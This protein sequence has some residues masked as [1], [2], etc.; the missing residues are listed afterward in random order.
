MP[1][2]TKRSDL[3]TWF[4]KQLRNAEPKGNVATGLVQVFDDMIDH[5]LDEN[6]SLDIVHYEW[7]YYFLDVFALIN[8][9]PGQ[10]R[11]STLVPEFLAVVYGEANA[12]GVVSG[13]RLIKVMMELLE[14]SDVDLKTVRTGGRKRLV[15]TDRFERQ[16]GVSVRIQLGGK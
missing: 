11:C 2:V 12:T 6:G 14:L 13:Q 15:S 7:V 16:Y 3:L 8:K 5:C 4:A 1:E 10:Q 9:F